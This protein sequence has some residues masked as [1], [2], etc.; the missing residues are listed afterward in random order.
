MRKLAI[1]KTLHYADLFDYPLRFEEIHKYLVEPLAV[2]VLEEALTQMGADVKQ[3]SADNGFYCLPGREE[4]IK[5]RKNR[6]V[7]SRSKIKKAKRIAGVLKFIPWIKLIGVTGAL[8]MG[9]SDENDDIDLMIITAPQRLWLT[10]GVVVTFLLLTSQY[11]RPKKV[12]DR[13]CPN[14]MISE[15]ALEFSDRDLFTAHEIIQMRPI[16]DRE[17]TYQKFI[18]AN[19]WVFDFLPNWKPKVALQLF[20][21]SAFS[22]QFNHLT[23]QPFSFLEK[24]AYKLQLKFMESK[25]TT[26][27]TTPSIIRFHPPDTRR[28]ILDEYQKR[29]YTIPK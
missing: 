15:N 12:K 11:R 19:R 28:R 24:L 13:I 20:S 25:K 18:N 7:Y 5:L 10:R 23:I 21:S 6:E 9:N 3:I 4:I 2:E 29:V 1:L 27:V 16:Y 22:E 8:A 17:N 14:L 26:E